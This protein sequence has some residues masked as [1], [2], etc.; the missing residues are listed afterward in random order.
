MTYAVH[1]LLSEWSEDNRHLAASPSRPALGRGWRQRQRDRLCSAGDASGIVGWEPGWLQLNVTS[2]VRQM[3]AGQPN[4]GWRRVPVSGYL[5]WPERFY[6]SE[7]Q[8][9]AGLRPKLTVNYS[10]S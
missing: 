9:K 4:R 1:R 2:A 7:S 10:I 6:S 5:E 3:S 8:V